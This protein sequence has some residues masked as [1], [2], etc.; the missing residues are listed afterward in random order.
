MIYRGWT[1]LWLRGG[2]S[3]NK[4]T[5]SF[6]RNVHNQHVKQR[7]NENWKVVFKLLNVDH[8]GNFKII[9]SR[10]AAPP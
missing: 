10:V 1:G 4:I 8:K 2:A 5:F 7:F 9:D 3:R 6:H